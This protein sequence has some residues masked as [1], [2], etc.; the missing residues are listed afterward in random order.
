MPSGSTRRQ[1]LQYASAVTAGF[2]GLRSFTAQGRALAADLTRDSHARFGELVADPQGVLDLPAG[3]RYQ[4]I[5]KVGERMDDG[6]FVPGLHDGMGAFP[7]P[8]GTTLL[9]RNHEVSGGVARRGPFGWS[10]EL[11]DRLDRAKTYDRGFGQTPSVGGTTTLV[12]DTR[13]QEL[14][15]HSLSLVGTEHNCAGGVTPWGTWVSCEESVIRASERCEQDH[16]YNFEVPATHEIGVV[17]P[18][19]LRAM[20]R[21]NHEAVAVDPESGAVYQ[22]EDR[23]DGVIYR[24]L[25]DQP[26]NLAAGGRLQALVIRDKPSCD[27]RNWPAAPAELQAGGAGAAQFEVEPSASETIE[28]GAVFEVDWIDLDDVESPEDDLR[29]RAYLAGAARFARAE[30]MWYGHESVYYACTTGGRNGKGQVW[31]YVPSRFEGTA[32]EARFP[33]RLELFIEPNDEALLQHADNLCVSPWGDVI[34]CEDG[35]P[36]NHIL[37]ITPE[38]GVYKIGRNSMSGSEFAGSCFSPDGT[39]L[40]V[41]IQAAGITLA[42]TGPWHD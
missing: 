16:G 10:N 9:L 13:R 34:A 5:S 18:V 32:A 11:F 2:T 23:Q 29:Y 17:D 33:G 19:P 38:G 20:G 1:F 12:Y 41:N 36:V 27:T 39:T 35:A 22:T 14:L 28:P 8:E 21:F 7:G 3:F 25:P 37:G 30:G 15:Q 31:R 42:V 24:F 6:F 26:G 40:F 4:V